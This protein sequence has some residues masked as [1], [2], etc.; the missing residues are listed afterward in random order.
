[1]NSL[2]GKRYHSAN[3][4]FN[5][6]LFRSKKKDQINRLGPFVKKIKGL[7]VGCDY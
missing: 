7:L 3:F 4:N 6:A 2:A 5:A 1:M